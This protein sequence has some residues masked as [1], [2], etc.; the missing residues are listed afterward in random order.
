MKK[1]KKVL[2]LMLTVV[3]L[4]STVQ[5]LA[6]LVVFGASGSSEEPAQATYSYPV[7]TAED[8]E[9]LKANSLLVKSADLVTQTTDETTLSTLGADLWGLSGMAKSKLKESNYWA[10]TLMHAN[11]RE[12]ITSYYQYADNVTLEPT[13]ADFY[14]TRSISSQ[15]DYSVAHVKSYLFSVIYGIS[16]TTATEI[17]DET[18]NE[19]IGTKYVTTLYF[20]DFNLVGNDGLLNR[21]YARTVTETIY[22]EGTGKT[23]TAS[24]S[25]YQQPSGGKTAFTFVDGSNNPSADG[26]AFAD[27]AKLLKVNLSYTNG[28]VSKPVFTFQGK[29]KVTD[30]DTGENTVKD[31]TAKL[32]F[33]QSVKS[34]TKKAF[35]FCHSN[36]YCA[37][38]IGGAF[39]NPTVTYD[40]SGLYKADANKFLAQYVAD[41]GDGSKFTTVEELDSF[42]A[43]Y[44]A[45][46][47]QLDS[48]VLAALDESKLQT[49]I[50]NKYEEFY[51][52]IFADF[53]E[54]WTN[55]ANK[56]VADNTI[57]DILAAEQ[58]EIDTAVS[59]IEAKRTEFETAYTELETELGYKLK[60]Y[61]NTIAIGN[62]FDRGLNNLQYPKSALEFNV[63]ETGTEADF[64][65]EVKD[66]V[67]IYY[68]NTKNNKITYVNDST[69]LNEIGAPDTDNDGVRNP[70]YR[71]SGS[72]AVPYNGV[73]GADGLVMEF[74]YLGNEELYP[75]LSI[76]A[77]MLLTADPY[78][79]GIGF[80]L[81]ATDWTVKEDGS[82]TRTIYGVNH[83]ISITSNGG[84]AVKEYYPNLI[85]NVDKDGNVT[86]YCSY[87]GAID[88][89]LTYYS[90]PTG[91]QTSLA[92]FGVSDEVI[93]ELN[94]VTKVTNED[95]WAEYHLTYTD[96]KGSAQNLSIDLNVNG[97]DF[98]LELGML[99]GRF[100]S[101]KENAK[102]RYIGLFSLVDTEYGGY[103][104]DVTVTYDT[105]DFFVGKANALWIDTFNKLK[106]DI[107][108]YSKDDMDQIKAWLD[109]YDAYG[110]SDEKEQSIKETVEKKIGTK[111]TALRNAYDKLSQD[112][113]FFDDF[114]GSLNWKADYKITNPELNNWRATVE[115]DISYKACT[116]STT[117]NSS[118]TYFVLDGSTYKVVD[119][120]VAEDIASYYTASGNYSYI[121]YKDKIEN[122]KT[123]SKTAA[124]NAGAKVIAPNVADIA[125]YVTYIGQY[126][127]YFDNQ[128]ETNTYSSS[129]ASMSGNA[130]GNAFWGIHTDKDNSTN[131]TLWLRKS[132]NKN[133]IHANS[134]DT[135][136]RSVQNK[137]SVMYTTKDGVLDSELYISSYSGKMYFDNLYNAWDRYK[138]GMGI[139]Y[140]YTNETSWNTIGL[141]GNGYMSN[142]SRSSELSGGIANSLSSNTTAISTGTK[143]P[144]Y[145]GQWLDFDLTYDFNRN[146]YVFTL[147]GYS[148][149]SSSPSSRDENTNNI[150]GDK[151]TRVFVINGATNLIKKVGLVNTTVTTQA[152]DDIAVQLV[153]ATFVEK[154][155]AEQ[156]PAINDLTVQDEELI[157]ATENVYNL[158]SDAEKAKVQNYETLV[159]ARAKL[160]ELIQARDNAL[161]L[162]GFTILD[163]EDKD[164]NGN[165]KH[166]DDIKGI[167]YFELLNSASRKAIQEID[168]PY[169]MGLNTSDKVMSI[170]R[171]SARSNDFAIYKIKDT[172]IDDENGEKAFLGNVS[173]KMYLTS[174]HRYGNP[175]IFIYDYQDED[176]WEGFYPYIEGNSVSFKRCYKNAGT[177]NTNYYETITAQKDRYYGDED[178]E[179]MTTTPGWMHVNMAYSLT[180]VTATVE[181]E[182]AAGERDVFQKFSFTLSDT[183]ATSVAFATF[184]SSGAYFDDIRV[185]L[186]E[187]DKN[188]YTLTKNFETKHKYLLNLRPSALYMSVT[189]ETELNAL[190]DDYNSLV[191][192]YE[193]IEYYM[194]YMAEKIEILKDSL[195]FAKNRDNVA[196]TT[197]RDNNK[198]DEV[199]KQNECVAKN[200]AYDGNYEVSEDFLNGYSLFRND[201]SNSGKVRTVEDGN[202]ARL[203]ADT[204]IVEGKTYYTKDPNAFRQ[205]TS[206]TAIVPGKTYYADNPDGGIMSVLSPVEADLSTYYDSPYARVT[207]PKKEEL[208]TYY[209][210]V[211]VLEITGMSR[212]TLKE[213]FLPEKP[214]VASISYRVQVKQT[215]E[216]YNS[217]R[218]YTDWRSES[219]YSGLAFN[220]NKSTGQTTVYNVSHNGI[221]TKENAKFNCLDVLTV[222]YSYTSSG[223]WILRISD[224]IG[225][226]MMFNGT[227]GLKAMLQLVSFNKTVHISDFRVY[228]DYGLWDENIENTE[229]YPYYEGNTYLNPGDLTMIYG[230]T[231]SA[232]VASVQM[233][234]ITNNATAD[235]GYVSRTHF[236]YDGVHEDEFSYDPTS[237][238]DPN[239]WVSAKSVK[240]VQRAED[241]IK[242]I[243][244]ETFT[245]GVYAVKLNGLSIDTNPNDFKIVYLNAPSIDYTIGLDGATG[246]PGTAMRI[247]GKNLSPNTTYTDEDD[248][249]TYESNVR[250]KLVKVEFNKTTDTALNE[251][252][253]YYT[254]ES[255]EYVAVTEPKVEDIGNYYERVKNGTQID[256]DVV[257][258][259]SDYSI[260]FLIPYDIPVPADGSSVKYEVYVHNGYGDDTAWSIPF[261][262]EFAK[263][264]RSTWKQTTVN[265]LDYVDSNTSKYNA[266]PG[267][268]NALNY[269]ASK[270]G[271]ILYLPAGNYRLVH[272]I[273]IP[274]NVQIKGE[275]MQDT[276]IV[277]SPY[278]WESGE[279]LNAVIK[280]SRNISISDVS[281]YA[282]RIGGI[283]KG[284]TDSSD[285]FYL[286]NCRL[287]TQ[288]T[289]GA[290]SDAPGEMEALPGS[291]DVALI[292]SKG[293]IYSV[294]TKAD[295]VNIINFDAASSTN[296]N[297]R[298]LVNDTNGSMYMW[299]VD[300]KFKGGWSEII[301]NRA[302]VEGC[303]FGPCAC[304]GIWGHGTYLQDNWLHDQTSNNRE[305]YVADRAA[306]YSGSITPYESDNNNTKFKIASS[307]NVNT[308]MYSQIYI[309]GGQ[310][311][312]QT[313]WIVGYDY[314]TGWFEVD[315][316]FAIAPN[317]NSSVIVR[318]PRENIYFVNNLWENGGAGGFYGGFADV[319][320][321][322]NVRR[323]NFSFY[324]ESIFNDVN[325]YLSI[326]NESWIY[327]P[328]NFMG[329]GM[330]GKNMSGLSWHALSGRNASMCFTL[331][332][333]DMDGA[334][335]DFH[336]ANSLALNMFHDVI[337]DNNRFRNIYG[338]ALIC[339][340]AQ[341]RGDSHLDGWVE[342]RNTFENC[343]SKYQANGHIQNVVPVA[344]KSTNSEGSKRWIYLESQEEEFFAGLNLGDIDNDGSV[345]TK[346]AVML[347]NYLI[348][349]I[350]LS[351]GQ[352]G[353]ADVDGDGIV[354]L[355]DVQEIKY[356]VAGIITVFPAQSV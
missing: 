142:I 38:D 345:T 139:V 137:P 89:S 233:M 318:R 165:E 287:Y 232:N 262:A 340:N 309:R 61:I 356:Y 92:K 133:N 141:D 87:V 303:E 253:V 80:T 260:D 329:V 118:T 58:S 52:A 171:N 236:D 148:N 194:P 120:P 4:L 167:Q 296:Q 91:T 205:R 315:R 74:T 229:I 226:Q 73:S 196:F 65:S 257:E 108:T 189:D 231:L 79:K 99:G 3:M 31:F 64:N 335:L 128:T 338:G 112:Y 320:Y 355:M 307:L 181:F 156:I 19:V 213:K 334:K 6:G 187:T 25:N 286:Q 321:D 326:V 249:S 46:K 353:R 180:S 168:N 166:P 283:I 104:S 157:I 24:F 264:L 175:P 127:D 230:D 28:D 131:S 67:T 214:H 269:L 40:L 293:V 39:A 238:A 30:A 342:Y 327:D 56:V 45:A 331:R 153:D 183:S 44:N 314:K 195:E 277:W 151:Q 317:R 330:V 265:I 18:T 184:S 94:K 140:R 197:E 323:A 177:L 83:G 2:A 62:I 305:L 34:G 302:I 14:Y 281:F 225:N 96:G 8:F 328:N 173:F 135:Y 311:E 291:M 105:S 192:N 86:T 150:K 176:N 304:I 294:L 134:G 122:I 267:F 57:D 70:V 204:E 21:R 78:Q 191:A 337:L 48:K 190:I 136:G 93:A 256:A 188:E 54:K 109:A 350:E 333:C 124:T 279:L 123:T 218:L 308:M 306:N 261:V 199:A 288:P 29:Y 348:G 186:K 20:A 149:S 50:D 290:P 258:V 103:I 246:A 102:Q 172:A 210:A 271:G 228:Y 98:T 5:C 37:L 351:S 71:I 75:S 200:G 164:D 310:G 301:C 247:I 223:S 185:N 23:N 178:Y 255:G 51:S 216:R 90:N 116:A 162:T 146:C 138:Y 292:E 207:D 47:E 354:S 161:D 110:L 119:N 298:P 117:F 41:F 243:I 325:W 10:A 81:G 193:T 211:E 332:N 235:L 212:L 227:A 11:D 55:A 159:A 53:N 316:P 160:N 85:Q 72:N 36:A 35:G 16:P 97:I 300:S 349:K 206:D 95:R 344:K 15:I 263:D 272:S 32:A 26:V 107:G 251:N 1:F 241:S 341:T 274:E 202:F 143:L 240:I 198:L 154:V 66:A 319:I 312:G 130:N 219:A 17:I 201:G 280:Y 295:N 242:F 203:T 346:D 145:R 268:V 343:G 121:F 285:N 101:N 266:T 222:S 347:R 111:I 224:E 252:K 217:F 270:G 352:L 275:S 49:L 250:V 324:Q 158:L 12:N 77:K 221:S 68:N 114:E 244:P 339:G 273:V 163:F 147:T 42:V 254:L 7:S 144:F 33:T 113:N 84:I 322:G 152:F 245:D 76:D 220:M 169:K 125:D 174:L 234:Q 297:Q 170:T 115:S 60:N 248:Y 27:M 259:Q 155:I 63:S 278:N 299:L 215:P 237:L 88:S 69:K 276:A 59:A 182:T 132:F 282:S 208:S 100:G 239:L 13:E 129:A 43:E 289:A 106:T 9:T 336:A 126:D 179:Q 284:Y 209:E 82:K 313:R 22:N